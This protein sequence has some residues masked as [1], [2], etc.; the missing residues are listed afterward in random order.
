M[1][2]TILDFESYRSKA[3]HT[4]ARGLA[5]RPLTSPFARHGGGPERALNDRQIAHR[6]RMLEHLQ[7]TPTSRS[8]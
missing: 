2:G 6:R 5:E 1:S 8:A 4:Q 7:S 3:G